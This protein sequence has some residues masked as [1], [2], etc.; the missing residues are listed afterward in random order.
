LYPCRDRLSGVSPRSTSAS[1]ASEVIALVV[2]KMLVIVFGFE[3]DAAAGIS[4]DV[5]TGLF[6]NSLIER[7][8]AFPIL[9]DRSTPP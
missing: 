2:A 3:H 1:A 8:C 7:S 4:V 6:D 9:S 5:E